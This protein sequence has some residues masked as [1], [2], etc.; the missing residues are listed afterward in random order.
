MAALLSTTSCASSA[1]LLQTGVEALKSFLDQRTSLTDKEIA[2]VSHNWLGRSLQFDVVFTHSPCADGRFAAWIAYKYNPHATVIPLEPQ[3]NTFEEDQVKDRFVLVLD[4]CFN[5]DAMVRLVTLAA[6][7]FVVDHHA[8]TVPTLRMVRERLASCPDSSNTMNH[9]LSTL[10]SLDD[11][12]S[13][14]QL[15]HWAVYPNVPMPWYLAYAG[16]ADLQHYALPLSHEINAALYQDRFTLAI[17]SK[18]GQPAWSCLEELDHHRCEQTVF[19]RA[20]QLAAE[21]AGVL[22]AQVTA[23]NKLAQTIRCISFTMPTLFVDKP[24]RACFVVCDQLALIPQLVN[25]MRTHDA[26]FVL[27]LRNVTN[28]KSHETICKL[29]LRRTTS[30]PTLDLDQ[31]ARALVP[32]G[33]GRPNA[34][35]ATLTLAEAQALLPV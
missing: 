15:L 22:A 10:L 25:T 4:Q 32:G 19:K 12:L 6:H 26:D 16:D 29:S 13:C 28:T 7:V 21:G 14:C 31:V 1:S 30:Q 18:S 11:Q 8:S 23:V 17:D 24:L 20:L 34:S 5:A 35:G 9:K 2:L 3:Q 27:V 33:G